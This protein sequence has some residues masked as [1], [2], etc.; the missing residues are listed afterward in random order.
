MNHWNFS[1]GD[2]INI[3]KMMQMRQ[4]N[5]MLDYAK[6]QNDSEMEFRIKTCI[7]WNWYFV[8]LLLDS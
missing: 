3:V 2:E 6:E 8:S 4:I 5:P 7:V 1:F